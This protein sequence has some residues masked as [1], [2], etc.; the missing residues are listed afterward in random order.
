M[1]V[2]VPPLL[3][4]RWGRENAE[5]RGRNDRREGERKCMIERKVQRQTS[6]EM[7]GGVMMSKEK[8]CL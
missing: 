2:V 4:E 6:K 1:W 8:G 5:V 7:K 3:V